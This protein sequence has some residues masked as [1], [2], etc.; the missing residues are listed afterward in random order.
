MSIGRPSFGCMLPTIG[1]VVKFPLILVCG[2][3]SLISS[4]SRLKIRVLQG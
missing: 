2:F 1:S 4:I 3:C